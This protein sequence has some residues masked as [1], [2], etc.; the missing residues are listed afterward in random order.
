MEMLLEIARLMYGQ[1]GEVT[2]KIAVLC[3]SFS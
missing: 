1:H 2:M 3:W